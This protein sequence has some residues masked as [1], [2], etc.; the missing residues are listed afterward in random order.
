MLDDRHGG[1]F[2]LTTRAGEGLR[3]AR[4]IGSARLA[5]GCSILLCLAVIWCVLVASGANA[6]VA[7]IFGEDP[8]TA[9][10]LGQN[11]VERGPRTN[12]DAARQQFL[13]TLP[14]TVAADESFEGFPVGQASQWT[15]IVFPGT[16][17]T[18]QVTFNVSV[19]MREMNDP[20]GTYNGCY[21]TD[22]INY[23]EVG[24]TSGGNRCQVAFSQP[25][26]GFG[27]YITDIEEALPVVTVWFTDGTTSA[28]TVP[29]THNPRR[30]GDI[31]FWGVIS[32][33]KLISRVYVSNLGNDNEAVGLDQLTIID[34][35]GTGLAPG[36]SN[37]A[38][39]DSIM[40][41]ASKR[42]FFRVWGRA[43][44]EGIGNVMLDDGS[45][46][47]VRVIAPGLAF[48]E[49][50]D[51]VLATGV[52]TRCGGLVTITCAP[53]QVQLLAR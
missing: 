3:E 26:R 6:D 51:C 33:S 9:A 28:Y 5:V 14:N 1:P 16:S 38:A 24:L 10:P 27:T 41:D 31:C 8:N 4:A 39:Y 49:S 43:T 42:F 45:G 32:D 11:Q 15:D 44:V 13:A 18:G 29:A 2:V 37:R 23:I 12:S 34:D 20:S 30:S 25:V 50:G 22:G 19:V 21:P 47:P 7:V 35:S 46:K 48:V 52:L 17:I 53:S 36:I 40:E